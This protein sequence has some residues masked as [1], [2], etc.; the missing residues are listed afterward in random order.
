MDINKSIKH[1][2]PIISDEYRKFA[3][4]KNACKKCHIYKNYNQVCQ[5]EGNAKDP[6]FV[7]VGEAP[8]SDEI[9]NMRPFIGAAGQRLRMELRK[10]K[11][12]FTKENTLIT[13]TISC[14]P[15]G[16]VYP[17][18]SDLGVKICVDSWLNRELAL[19]KPKIIV[20]V[21]GAALSAVR[22]ETGI[23]ANRGKWKFLSPGAT[24]ID[25]NGNVKKYV[26]VP[27][28]SHL[29][30]WTLATFHPSY[31]LKCEGEG[32]TYVGNLFSQDIES[33][34]TMYKTLLSDYRYAAKNESVVHTFQKLPKKYPKGNLGNL[35]LSLTGEQ[36]AQQLGLIPGGTTPDQ[37][38]Y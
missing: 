15:Q 18:D 35:G 34:A 30:A 6:V 24:N 12:V 29:K 33:V 17:G 16:N 1:N 14:R 23:T 22:R 25:E 36:M 4:E 26:K 20:L 3:L 7:F 32:N 2:F 37:V 5:S 8:G 21:G 28:F 9:K 11:D 13:N 31:V 19:L 27:F 38:P 10:Y